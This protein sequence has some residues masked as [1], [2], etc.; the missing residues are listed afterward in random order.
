MDG[1]G[2]LDLY[3]G[4]YVAF[5]AHSQPQMCRL[6]GL[7]AACGPRQYPAEYGVLYRNRGGQGFE[8]ATGGFAGTSSG[9]T[10]G[11]AFADYDYSGRQSLAIGNDATPGDLLQNRGT[12]FDNIG[13]ISGVALGKR[14]EVQAGMGLDWGDFD[15]DGKLDL[16]LATF[17]GETKSLYRNEGDYF[18]EVS[19][20]VGL[21]AATNFLSFGVKWLDYDNDGWLDLMIANGHI[22]S[23]AA[24]LRSDSTFR[25]TTLLFH[26]EQGRFRDVS[27]SQLS[28]GARR[29]IVGRG[30]AVGDYD[31]DGRMDALLVDS[32]G[33][34]ILLH[35][36]ASPVG[37]WI[38]LRLDDPVTRNR[39]A[40][41]A[42]VTITDAHGRHLVRVCQT[43]G[44]YLSSSD[45]RVLF[46]LGAENN[47][48]TVM[49]RWP[50]GGEETWDNVPINAYRTLT[51]GTGQE[52]PTSLP[53]KR[54][55][56]ITP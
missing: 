1:D 9:R 16:I 25:Q 21:G 49:V 52:T 40:Y 31:N 47:P 30:L 18:T 6:N 42:N 54:T 53:P 20:D 14:G 33:A 19:S 27:S 13:E 51:H 4:A 29:P 2:W 56:E 34:P 15:N 5:D 55:Q 45:A 44:A 38:G 11:V 50:G 36:R 35:N 3:V 24:Q 22:Q 23:N 37:H 32:D 46:G 26:N 41:G 7:P 43:G 12:D 17:E 10:L 48:V 8:A 28:D 39:Q